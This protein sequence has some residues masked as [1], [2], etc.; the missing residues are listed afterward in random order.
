[1]AAPLSHHRFEAKHPRDLPRGGVRLHDDPH[2][3]LGPDWVHGLLQG[4]EQGRARACAQLDARG[5]GEIV[6]VL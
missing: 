3:P 5:G 2:L 4:R 1:M 6:P